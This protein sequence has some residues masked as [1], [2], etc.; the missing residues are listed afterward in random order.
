MNDGKRGHARGLAAQSFRLCCA[1]LFRT[2][3]AIERTKTPKSRPCRCGQAGFSSD[4]RLENPIFDKGF[5]RSAIRP[6]ARIGSDVSD[7]ADSG[8]HEIPI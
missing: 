1:T 5:D 6:A 7:L 3:V 4:I 2:A 8:A